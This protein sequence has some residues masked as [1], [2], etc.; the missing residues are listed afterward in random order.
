MSTSGPPLLHTFPALFDRLPW[1]KIADRPSRVHPLPELGRTVGLS[2]LWI[3][4][5]DENSSV[6]SGNKVRKFEYIFGELLRREC[7]E[8]I[9]AGGIGSNHAVATVLFARQFGLASVLLSV[10]QPVLS[11]VRENILLTASLGMEIHHYSNMAAAAA[12]GLALLGARTLGR[13]AGRARFITF[14][15]S[16]PTGTVAFVDAA[17]ELKTQIDAGEMPVPEYIFVA[18]GSCGTMAGLVAGL[19][20][21]GL[22][23]K[24]VGVRVVDKIV[25]NRFVVSRLANR[26]I[27]HLRRLDPTVPAVR[28]RAREITLLDDFFGG[29]YGRPT[30]EG[31]EAIRLLAEHNGVR[32]DPTYTGKAFA[33]MLDY[34]RRA[35]VV[36]GPSLFWHTRNGVDLSG[37]IRSGLKPED[38]PARLKRYFEDP[39]YDPEL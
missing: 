4:R 10:D 38:L 14:G 34:L 21:A 29:A 19:R 32:L 11:Y 3:K 12:G 15:G 5:D 16:S 23:T 36:D 6:Y 22:P 30:P 28:V 2:N 8:V 1:V 37:H 27:A 20:I 33:G 35:E 26:T 18:T 9:T 25:T 7:K 17:L 13:R 24:V 31:K 39:L